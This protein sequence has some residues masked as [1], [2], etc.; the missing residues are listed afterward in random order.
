MKELLSA[1]RCLIVINWAACI[2]Q[3]EVTQGKT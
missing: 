1:Q 3:A 2:S